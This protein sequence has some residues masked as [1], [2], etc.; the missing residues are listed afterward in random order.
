[1]QNVMKLFRWDLWFAQ[2]PG[3]RAWW[4]LPLASACSASKEVVSVKEES[5]ISYVMLPPVMVC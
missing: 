5:L 1:M 3:L 2:V 4:S